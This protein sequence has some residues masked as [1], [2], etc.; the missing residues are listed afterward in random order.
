[1]PVHFPPGPWLRLMWYC[2]GGDKVWT[3]D[4]WYKITSSVPSG[5][6]I[7]TVANNCY[8]ALS[9]PITQFMNQNYNLNGLKVFLNNGTYTVGYDL[10]SPIPGVQNQNQLP[11]EVA[12]IG[13]INAGIG[14]RQGSGRLFIAGLDSQV[15]NGN[16]PS[17]VGEG[18][19][20]DLMTALK[21]LTAPGGLSTALA[22][23]DRKTATLPE[24]V[25]TGIG[26]IAS[27][28]RRRRPRF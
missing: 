21:G 16:R 9:G 15:L 25:F 17:T 2:G 26:P 11:Q 12:V 10:F 18:F 28:L 20:T 3:N 27:T 5:T 24:P 14:T 4:V 1:M 13:T 6:N 22:V 8:S 23:W 7:V 19:M